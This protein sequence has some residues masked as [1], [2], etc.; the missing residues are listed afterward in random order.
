MIA[1]IEIARSIIGRCEN[2]GHVELP[3]VTRE[4][5]KQ[6]D[7]LLDDWSDEEDLLQ[8]VAQEPGQEV[9]KEPG[10]EHAPEEE[11]YDVLGSGQEEIEVPESEASIVQQE[12]LPEWPYTRLLC[13]TWPR[14]LLRLMD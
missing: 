11:I 9:E 8:E 7:T 1:I 3:K 6:A 4:T 13:S 10:Q 12:V 5:M 14:I 2:W